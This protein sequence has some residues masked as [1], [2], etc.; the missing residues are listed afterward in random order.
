MV[1]LK[2]LIFS[3]AV[4]FTAEMDVSRAADVSALNNTNK[5]RNYSVS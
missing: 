4:G 1:K 5:R 2:Y 3:V